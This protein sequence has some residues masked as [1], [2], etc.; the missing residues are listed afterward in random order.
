MTENVVSSLLV[1][2]LFACIA[3]RGC[4]LAP[5]RF[6]PFSDED[7][8]VGD[9]DFVLS[10]SDVSE[11]LRA[12]RE[13]LTGHSVDFAIY[14][15]KVGKIRLAILADDKS[16][17]VI[18]EL[19]Q[20]LEARALPDTYPTLRWLDL[21]AH[22]QPD[23]GSLTGYRIAP[24]VEAAYYLCHLQ[25]KQKKIEHG[26]TSVRLKRY[27]N[28]QELSTEVSAIVGRIVKDADIPA[29]ALSARDY[30]V[31]RNILRRSEGCWG[32]LHA[33]INDIPAAMFRLRLSLA[34]S[35]RFIDFIGPDGVGKTSLIEAAAG[36]VFPSGKYF[37]FKKTYR[38]SISYSIA[39]PILKRVFQGKK[40]QKLA[41]NQ[42]DDMS[43][44]FLFYLS[45]AGI[46]WRNL[47]CVMTRRI[48]LSDRSPADLLVTGY[49][50]QN[51]KIALRS[52]AR[53][54][55][56]FMPTP[57]AVVHLHAPSEVITSRKQEMN[58]EQISDYQSSIFDVYLLKTPPI[59]IGINTN[60]SLDKSVSALAALVNKGAAQS[61]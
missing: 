18:I 45:V 33:A 20:E 16:R 47:V 36:K 5:I 28:S 53:R 1:R 2:Q 41:K 29:A 11:T 32:R 60:C 52:T 57:R 43:S 55:I 12:I 17:Q 21:Q 56:R 39:H 27:Q 58:A 7:I 50:F 8:F 22:I 51:K 30:L 25:E 59:Y 54:D 15:R 14:R 31:S 34:G 6:K 42:V 19:W 37:R 26:L 49:R 10:P 9:Y 13:F 40:K 4:V 24:D 3:G 61:G 48:Y 44:G 35:H 38:K 23:P 46:F